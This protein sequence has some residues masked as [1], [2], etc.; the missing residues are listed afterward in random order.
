MR[1]WYRAA[2]FIAESAPSVVGNGGTDAA[3]SLGR[4]GESPLLAV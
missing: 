3:C 2:L 4:W 1:L